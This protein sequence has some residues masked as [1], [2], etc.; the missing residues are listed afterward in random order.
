MKNISKLNYSTSDAILIN[1]QSRDHQKLIRISTENETLFIYVTTERII[2][3]TKSLNKIIKKHFPNIMPINYAKNKD[4]VIDNIV[5][6]IN[7]IEFF[8]KID[9][10]REFYTFL[11]NNN[12]EDK[13]HIYILHA[14]LKDPINSKK[15]VPYRFKDKEK[16][17]TIII[18]EKIEVL[19][20]VNKNLSI[21]KIKTSFILNESDKFKDSDDAII[22]KYI[23]KVTGIDVRGNK[24]FYYIYQTADGQLYWYVHSIYNKHWNFI[25]TS[26]FI[27]EVL[28]GKFTY[29]ASIKRQKKDFL[30]QKIKEEGQKKQELQK[31]QESQQIKHTVLI[32]YYKL[33]KP[34]QPG[35]LYLKNGDVY[36]LVVDKDIIDDNN[37][38]NTYYMLVNLNTGQFEGD[39]NVNKLLRKFTYCGYEEAQITVIPKKQQTDD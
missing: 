35:S 39:F 12:I 19:N 11:M 3:L 16:E 28:T 14:I 13:M 32:D 4:K 36:I 23:L 27:N 29:E 8:Y 10:L 26:H 37:E 30:K 1:N 25:N 9:N 17:D 6:T 24:K 18:P 15:R 34:T 21:Q 22:K 2:S 20:A 38:N 7:R 5:W 33:D 31:Q